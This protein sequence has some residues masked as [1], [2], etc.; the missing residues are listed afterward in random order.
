M[1]NHESPER[2]LKSSIPSGTNYITTE[3]TENTETP[4]FVN[5]SVVINRTPNLTKKTNFECS[6]HS[7]ILKAI[8]GERD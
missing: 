6:L 7:L 4:D 8:N 2:T 5:F 3:V 1:N